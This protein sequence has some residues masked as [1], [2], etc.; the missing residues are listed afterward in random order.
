MKI[1]VSVFI[2]T[3]NEAQYIAQ[4][5]QSVSCCDEVIVVDSGSI[6]GTQAIAQSLGATVIHRNWDGY[7]KQKQFALEQCRNEW[8]L[9]LDGD[10]VMAPEALEELHNIIIEGKYSSYRL[11]RVDLFIN[12]FPSKAVKKFNNVRAYKKSAAA[13]PKDKLVHESAVVDGKEFYSNKHFYHYGYNHIETLCHKINTYS[14]LRAQEKSLANKQASW[15]K[16]ILLYP[17]TFIKEYFIGRNF[18]FGARGFIRSNILAFYSLL[19]EAKLYEYNQNDQ[20]P[21]DE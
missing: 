3:L 10:E 20:D 9:N 17:L 15:I 5:I 18:L 1:P 19:K 8:V 13:F 11:R 2:V 12:Q 4:A 14:S 16:L 6:D 7:S 21:F